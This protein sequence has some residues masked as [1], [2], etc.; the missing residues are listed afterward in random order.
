MPSAAR[1]ERTLDFVVERRAALRRQLLAT[2]VVLFVLATW[3]GHGTEF[4]IPKLVEGLPKYFELLGRMMPPD[5][6][7]LQS[8]LKPLLE[9][10]E[11]A[12][13]G[14]TIP[15]FFALPLAF[16]A[17]VNVSPQQLDDD[18]FADRDSSLIP[19]TAAFRASVVTRYRYRLLRAERR[20]IEAYLELIFEVRTAPRAAA[21]GGS[22]GFAEYISA[23]AEPPE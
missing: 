21:P 14:T 2:A 16:L 11:M 17:A 7:V 12:L 6:S 8:L 10:L 22:V 4:N 13:L 23:Q 18:K 19:R 20:V 3:A 5:L 9:T 1:L 15:V